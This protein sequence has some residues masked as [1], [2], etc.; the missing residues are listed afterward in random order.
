MN[1]KI[2]RRQFLQSGAATLAASA[3]PL[4]ARPDAA[5]RKPW[6]VL[7]VISDQ[8][9]AAC[10]GAEGHPQAI[11]P[12]W[13][14]WPA[15]ECALPG[16]TP[17][18]PSARPAAP[19]F[20][21]GSTFT[22]MAT[23]DCVVRRRSGFAQRL[24]AVSPQ[25]ISHGGNREGSHAG[26]THQLAR[27]AIAMPSSTP[28]HITARMAENR[29]KYGALPGW[30]GLARQR[31]LRPASG[32]SGKPAERSPA[33]Q[34]SLPALAGRLDALRSIR[35]MDESGERPFMLQCFLAADRTN[36]TR[37]T[38]DSGICTRTTSR[39]RRRFTIP[40]RTGLRISRRW[41]RS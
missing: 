5:S 26:R 24:P 2:H 38:G 17:K 28:A 30:A 7:Y 31:G 34:S 25:W 37:R 19:A 29:A 40:P 11:T 36:A 12:T 21:P 35:F 3:A 13:I 16:A 1:V 39:F 8:H 32:I 10:M 23:T 20:S 18:T 22:I 9:Q 33:I 41:W 15:A 14:A 4:R 6:N 27:P